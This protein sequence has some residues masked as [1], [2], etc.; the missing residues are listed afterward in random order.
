MLEGEN[1]IANL[2][3]IILTNMRLIQ[4]KTSLLRFEFKAFY[5]NKLDSIEVSKRRESKLLILEAIVFA[6]SV[7]LHL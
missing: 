2:G 1:E 5:L 6:N 3:Y 7:V 4:E